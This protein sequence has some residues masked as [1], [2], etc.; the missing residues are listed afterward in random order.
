MGC[1]SVVLCIEQGRLRGT[2]PRQGGDKKVERVGRRL[3][4][5]HLSLCFKSV[6]VE[7]GLAEETW[8]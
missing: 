4:D 8:G 3:Y 6:L 5:Q 7:K 1:A 2:C